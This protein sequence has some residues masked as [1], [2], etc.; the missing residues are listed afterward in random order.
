LTKFGQFQGKEVFGG[1]IT[2]LLGKA[3]ALHRG[4]VEAVCAGGSLVLQ[5]ACG[6]FESVALRTLQ[7]LGLAS[8][9]E[10]RARLVLGSVVRELAQTQRSLQAVK[11]IQAALA[12]WASLFIHETDGPRQESVVADPAGKDRHAGQEFVGE[13]FGMG[14]K[15]ERV[16]G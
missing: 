3:H 1:E 9:P 12:S 16:T 6:D 7:N 5:D 13:A 2:C 4:V 11:P 15:A 8:L 10:Q 14:L